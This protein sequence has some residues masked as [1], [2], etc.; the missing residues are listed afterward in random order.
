M[1]VC[2]CRGISD[3]GFDEVSLLVRLLEDDRQ[4]SSCIDIFA[5]GD[6][7]RKFVRDFQRA[8]RDGLLKINFTVGNCELWNSLSR[9]EKFKT[10]NQFNEFCR[11]SSVEEQ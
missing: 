11:H 2:S 4:C 9:E 7:E 6:E 3:H 8:K 1:I 5:M 10:I